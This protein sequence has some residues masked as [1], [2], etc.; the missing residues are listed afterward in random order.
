M[1]VPMSKIYTGCAIVAAG[2]LGF[3]VGEHVA[4]NN[5]TTV[6]PSNPNAPTTTALGV[7]ANETTTTIAVLPANFFDTLGIDCSDTTRT[8]V[9]DERA[10]IGATLSLLKAIDIDIPGSTSAILPP[11]AVYPFAK[12]IAQASGYPELDTNTELDNFPAGT[13]TVPTGCT[14]TVIGTFIP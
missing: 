9:I 2:F 13:Y 7:I 11:D 8:I 12:K 3:A 6:I 5:E 1:V 14:N 10:R 4:K